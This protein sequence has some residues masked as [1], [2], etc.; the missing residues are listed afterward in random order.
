M[1]LHA[2]SLEPIERNAQSAPMERE[3]MEQFMKDGVLN[4]SDYDAYLNSLRVPNS[5]KLMGGGGGGVPSA[6]NCY[7]EPDASYTLIN[8]NLFVGGALDGAVGPYPI[9]FPY[10]FFG[11]TKTQFWINTK[12]TITFN[13]A[14]TTF[15][16]VGFPINPSSMIAG[17]WSD[18]DIRGIG[19][20]YFK[21]TPTAVYVNFVDVG[22]Y[23]NHTEKT[24]TFQMI[25]T[26]GNDPVIG[27][28]NNLAFCYKDM[29]W[30]AGDWNGGNG[31]FGGT[32][33][34]T[35]GANR[36]SGGDFFQVG[37]FLNNGNAYD[38]PFGNNDGIN[39]LDDRSFILDAC[40]AAENIPP[41][42]GTTSACDTVYL[43]Q[44]E[45]IEID[46][47]FFA[48]EEDQSVTITVDDSGIDGFTLISSS[49]GD[50]AEMVGTIT[51]TPDNVGQNVLF[52]TG[53]DDG[54]PSQS[55]TIT[56]VVIVTDEEI[57]EIDISGILNFCGGGS[58]ILT[59]TDGFD[60]YLWST[61][62]TTQ[63]CE[64]FDGGLVT[65]TG[66]LGNCSASV[67]V[68]VVETDY[69][70]PQLTAF[71]SPICSNDS[72]QV[73][74]HPSIVDDF[75]SF[76][77]DVYQDYPG[78]VFGDTTQS[79][80][81]A[82]SGTF[83]VQVE[84]P[85]GCLGQRIFTI[86]ATDANIPDDTFSGIYCDDLEPVDFCCGSLAATGGNFNMS[87]FTA[88]VNTGPWST[89]ASVDV[90]LNG[91]LVFDNIPT[92]Q[93]VA[94][95]GG[96]IVIS[97]PGVS[98][99]D[100]I[101][102]IYDNPAN[103]AL[104]TGLRLTNCVLFPQIA[105]PLDPEGG[106]V[107]SSY[108]NCNFTPAPGVWSIVSGPPGAS[109][110]VTNQFNTS[111]TPGDLGTY[112]LEYFSQTCGIT[113]NYD[114]EFNVLPV[115]NIMD[116]S[117]TICDETET[118]ISAEL[119]DPVGNAVTSWN[120]GDSPDLDLTISDS[121]IYTITA[122]NGCG[123][124]SDSLELFLTPI[125]SISFQSGAICDGSPFLLDPIAN[126][127]DSY[128][129][130]WSDGLPS[131]PEVEV[132]SPGEYT[133]TVSNECGSD[134]E[135]VQVSEIP[136]PAAELDDLLV[137][138]QGT[139]TLD[140]IA[141]DDPSF[142]YEWTGVSS[143]DPTVEITETGTYSVT[144][145][146]D[147]GTSTASAFVELSIA[148]E[149]FLQ[150]VTA[151]DGANII[152]DPIAFD[153]TNF[154][155]TWNNG[156]P[157]DPF[158]TITESG[159]Y[160]VTVSNNCGSSSAEA[161]VIVS[162]APSPE[163][164]D[165]F[166]CEG[167]PVVLDPIAINDPTFTYDWNNGLPS[168]A[169]VNITEA[170]S[171]TVVVT[172]ECGNASATAVV[173]TELIPNPQLNDAVYCVGQE[174]VLDPIS[175]DQDYYQYSWSEGLPSDSE[176]TINESGEYI[177][178]VSSACGENTSSAVIDFVDA[179]AFELNDETLCLDSQVT[180]SV[181]A[182]IGAVEW[183]DG[184]TNNTLTVNSPGTYSVTV[185]SNCGQSFSESAEVNLAIPPSVVIVID[186][187]RI[188]AGIVEQMNQV[189]YEGTY[190]SVV[191]TIEDELFSNS[192]YPNVVSEDIPGELV[193]IGVPM[194]VNVI[195]ECGTATDVVF[196]EPIICALWGY[197]V[198]SPNDDGLNDVFVVGGSYFFD[199][200][201][202]KVFNRWGN[203]VYD[204][205][206]YKND[207]EANGLEEGTYFYTV[208]TPEEVTLSG[209]FTLVR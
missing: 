166:F 13:A 50:Y 29:Q 186:T 14:N 129:Y 89:G 18:I 130:D 83:I 162:V 100:Y 21:I 127:D 177:V 66:Y 150:D 118:T 154:V 196:L 69:F 184:S 2:Q 111:F 93:Q 98:Y 114:L 5:A 158:V 86:G 201:E 42:P 159:L 137:C 147:C 133:V 138:D 96:V 58:T 160:E 62:C 205:S 19:D 94:N 198:F 99:G 60:S 80:I 156:L 16:P 145:S 207:W 102:I 9:G 209:S 208:N 125:P 148:P 128:M 108:T 165:V 204:D 176:V 141:T 157:S 59:A 180:L 35:V 82:S 11:D 95:S 87:F 174:A 56:F 168:T 110:S 8:Q 7:Q 75:D 124:D 164:S 152:L 37:R 15:V 103:S 181:P 119:I 38:G 52:V 116:E 163:L 57:P 67:T 90:Y 49:E 121:G 140:P 72:T 182:G 43:C 195:G 151:C 48:P 63:S 187:L 78:I 41:V 40:F 70:I 1:I 68:T 193:N 134:T 112:E 107:F 144:V 197:N 6:C 85:A 185:T 81:Y 17:Y 101:E 172:N 146:N 178:V 188:C 139:T 106:V 39:W 55:T 71:T 4:V 191:W 74:I 117:L 77:W 132:S 189:Y 32:A 20:I 113:Y 34:S 27:V 79:C 179:I 76:S 28:G 30:A 65:V 25:M 149:A 31:G 44:G 131:D 3:N 192:E 122:T 194:V 104:T 136:V 47:Q 142:S 22:Y 135:S 171:Y 97:I 200:I 88:G 33:A 61:G 169:E 126:D 143:I 91:E 175:D 173:T 12:G 115:V 120:P 170:G 190:T 53:T 123:A 51:G 10:C 84:T 45:T 155:Y 199:K 23:N 203:L 161:N 183:S 46:A 54:V 167:D 24:N 206:D 64:I 92:A 36:G 105:V 73:C 153:I 202:L 109:F 26:N